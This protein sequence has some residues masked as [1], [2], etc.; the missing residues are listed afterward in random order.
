LHFFAESENIDCA[1]G[2]GDSELTSLD[3]AQSPQLER[4]SKME[5]KDDGP[6]LPDIVHKSMD[7]EDAKDR[8]I[9]PDS[10]VIGGKTSAAMY[11]FMPPDGVKGVDDFMEESHYYSTYKHNTSDI[12]FPVEDN[13]MLEFPEKL[14][15]F[16]FPNGVL[17]HF[18]SPRRLHGTFLL[19]WVLNNSTNLFE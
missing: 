3:L 5:D 15:A 1:A 19:D 9:H 11:E 10:I 12:P 8:I 6:L 4:P 18:K 16:I 13:G 17:D 7:K 14:D 2:P